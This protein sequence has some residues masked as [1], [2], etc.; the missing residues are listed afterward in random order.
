MSATEPT[1]EA[2]PE[3]LPLNLQMRL[4]QGDSGRFTVS[5]LTKLLRVGADVIKQKIGQ[6]PIPV[7]PT[8]RHVLYRLGDV[9][10]LFRDARDA[11]TGVLTDGDLVPQSRPANAPRK[12]SLGLPKKGRR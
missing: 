9:A 5:E 12:V 7:Y 6:H 11:T 8:G 2:L 3:G 10:E 1:P 4:A